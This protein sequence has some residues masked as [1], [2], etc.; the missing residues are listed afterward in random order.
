MLKTIWNN[1]SPDVKLGLV[2]LAGFIF[3]LIFIVWIL[4]PT[5]IGQ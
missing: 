5:I 4:A 3:T 1:I 2:I